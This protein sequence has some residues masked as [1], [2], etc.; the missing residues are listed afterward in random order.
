MASELTSDLVSFGGSA[1]IATSIYLA[2]RMSA[3]SSATLELLREFHSKEIS[4]AR[5]KAFRHAIITIGKGEAE[6]R[7]TSPVTVPGLSSA[8]NL[9]V[10]TRFF[11]R[12]EVMRRSRMISDRR[13]LILFGPAFGY[14]WGLSYEQQM[15]RTDSFRT[16]RDLK[17][18]YNFFHRRAISDHRTA[19]WAE[20]IDEG[21]S[22]RRLAEDACH[23]LLTA[24]PRIKRAIRPR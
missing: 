4:E 5:T 19:E 14:W 17:S 20:W 11:S 9:F 16:R 13:L 6:W 12:L 1:I 23:P 7:D 8:E 24:P 3:R 2:Q 21:R 15:E 10:L 22:E 18:L